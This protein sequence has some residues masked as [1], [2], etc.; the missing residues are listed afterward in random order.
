MKLM[1]WM[2]SPWQLVGLSLVALTAAG[3][4]RADDATDAQAAARDLYGRMSA[5]DRDGV[6]RYIPSDG[7]TEL[8]SGGAE[9]HRLDMKAFDRLFASDSKIDLRLI[10]SEARTLGDV[11]IVTG[12]REG[13]VIPAG[14]QPAPPAAG[15]PVTLIW[16]RSDGRWLLQHVHLSRA[17]R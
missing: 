10:N 9:V 16:R 2:A 4:A 13:G 3:N 15:Q 5:R 12:V 1:S 14:Q 7:F 8:G 11:A 6:A 17:E